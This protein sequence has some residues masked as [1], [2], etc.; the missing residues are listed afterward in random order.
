MV[1]LCGHSD[2]PFGSLTL[3]SPEFVQ[4]VF[5]N[6]VRASKKTH[7][8]IAEINLVMLFKEI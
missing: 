1:G 4:M 7:F 2:K 5:K 8:T 3:Q 6:P